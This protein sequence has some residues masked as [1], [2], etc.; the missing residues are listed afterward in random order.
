[1]NTAELTIIVVLAALSLILGVAAV[2]LLRGR[3]GLDASNRVE[4]E[5][6]NAKLQESAK[7]V[8][9]LEQLKADKAALEGHIRSA[10][11]E[12]NRLTDELSAA[13]TERDSVK[14][15]ADERIQTEREACAQAIARERSAAA[16]L[17]GKE[18]E[19]CQ[20]VLSAKDGELKTKDLQIQNLK[21]FIEKANEALG[22]QFKALSQQTLKDV[23]AQFERAA[24][25]VIDQSSET[26]TQNVK[27]H[28][29]Q[30]EKLLQPV[31]L[32]LG[33]LNK[34]VKDTNEKRGEA[35]AVLMDK[36]KDFAG[37][38]EKLAN[39]LNKPVIRGSFAE[40]KL[41]SLLEA[42]GLV[43]G[44]NFELQ[45]QIRDGDQT[46][47]V[48]A[49]VDMAQGKKLVIDSKNLL[50]P[51][52]EYANAAEEDKAARLADFQRAFRNTLKA[53]SAKDYSKHWE[54]ID[55]II[56]FL[57][58]EG[59]YMAAI[60]ADRQLIATMFEQ[61]VF[62][63]SPV[64][65][66]PILKTVAY[67]LGLE[68]QNRDTQTIVDA[69]RALYESLGIILGKVKTLGDKLEDGVEAYNGV[70]ASFEGNVLPKT[71]HLRQLG[72]SRGADHKEIHLLETQRRDFKDRVVREL[73]ESG[74]LDSDQDPDQDA[75]ADQGREVSPLNL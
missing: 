58:D 69:G 17:V 21:E 33:E 56:M 20:A 43:R 18:K 75:F 11:I 1:M 31:G 2:L 7:G 12:I 40:M 63:V 42:A 15:N 51:Y 9:Q 14:S 3:Q 25:Q 29:E 64:S 62:T 68:K 5:L 28:K 37:A 70:I 73:S 52:V 24:K 57:P 55:A 4:I 48:D 49:L 34:L 54:G 39:A 27:L 46:R 41:E 74:Q 35:E 47:I 36:I 22:T 13:R 19:A 59:M 71:R 67:I 50:L 26:T 44:E 61:R 10:Q 38:N 53:L 72:I 6:L 45:V 60:E 66:L 30:I 23:S 16:E 32:T 65:L 8:G